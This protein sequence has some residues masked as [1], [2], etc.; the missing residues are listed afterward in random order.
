VLET[1]LAELTQQAEYSHTLPPEA[2]AEKL[3]LLWYQGAT[4]LANPQFEAQL[5]KAPQWHW[6][7]RYVVAKVAMRSGQWQQA[8][9]KLTTLWAEPSPLQ[10]ASGLALAS[11]YVMQAVVQH[12]NPYYLRWSNLLN[13]LWVGGRTLALA[14]TSRT[15]APEDK[16]QHVAHA[17]ATLW[18]WLVVRPR[19]N[20]ETTRGTALAWLGQQRH[21]FAGSALLNTLWGEALLLNRQVAQAQFWVTE[22]HQRHPNHVATWQHMAQVA[23][24]TQQ[25]AQAERWLKA[26]ITETPTETAAYELLA[27][28]YWQQGQK[29]QA[30]EALLVVLSLEADPAR[31]ARFALTLAEW[32]HSLKQSM[33]ALGY[34][35]LALA[36]QPANTEARQWLMALLREQNAYLALEAHCQLASGQQPTE[37][38]T[39]A[40]SLG[41]VAGETGHDERAKRLYLDALRHNPQD[42]VAA[43]NL[44]CLYMEVFHQPA[45]AEALLRSLLVA[46]NSVTLAHFN[47]GRALSLQGKALEAAMAYERARQLNHVTHDLDDNELA[48][49]LSEL[50]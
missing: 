18:A 15:L 40:T 38:G 10:M 17:K 25:P 9:S 32:Y 33:A 39:W 35:Q 42:T 3:L 31:K 47:L 36:L 27:A 30:I 29:P 50:F 48:S 37:S 23:L 6:A 24:L 13:A 43:N 11:C 41:Y 28:L 14:A 46:D 4:A 34:V 16:R 26:L 12:H 5:S 2:V 7:T 20:A 1:R 22:A 44:A 8:I 21:R 49:R 45:E 19:L